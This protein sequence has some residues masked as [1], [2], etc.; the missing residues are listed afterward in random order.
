VILLLS[1]LHD[2]EDAPSIY[3]R[4]TRTVPNAAPPEDKRIDELGSQMTEILKIMAEMKIN[5][6]QLQSTS[7]FEGSSRSSKQRYE[8]S[9]DG[10]D[11]GH[12]VRSSSPGRRFDGHDDFDD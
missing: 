4:E 9:A 1:H 2:L 11:P 3:G 6:V 5:N 10:S 8:N 12:D 7:R